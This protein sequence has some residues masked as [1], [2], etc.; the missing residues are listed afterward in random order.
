MNSM[1]IVKNISGESVFLLDIYIN[2]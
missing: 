2:R 1:I